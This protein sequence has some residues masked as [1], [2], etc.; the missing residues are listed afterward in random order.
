[1]C[2]YHTVWRMRA[3]LF[4]CVVIGG[5]QKKGRAAAR[6]EQSRT[7]TSTCMDVSSRDRQKR[8]GIAKIDDCRQITK[9]PENQ[10]AIAC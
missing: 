3:N 1:M 6:G 9:S 10:K 2:L 5:V 4:L 8:D 7:Y